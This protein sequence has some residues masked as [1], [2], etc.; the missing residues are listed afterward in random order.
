MKQYLDGLNTILDKGILTKNR[1]GVDTI[2]KFGLDIEYNL[3]R[4]V[5]PLLTTKRV[6]TTSIIHELIW[7]LSGDTNIKYLNDNK[8]TIWDEWAD[9]NGNLNK[10]YG[11]QWRNWDDTRFVERGS[12]EQQFCK[13][14]N[15][16]RVMFDDLHE[17]Y[18]RKIDQIKTIEDQ[19]KNNANSR[20]IIL[21]AWNTAEINEMALPPCHTLSQF[22]TR[23]FEG[24]KILDCKLYQRSADYFLGVPFNIAF[25][26][27]FTHMLAHV[28]G[29]TAG[30]LYHSIGDAHIYANHQDQVNTQLMRTIDPDQSLP[31]VLID[32]KFDSILDI[33]FENIIIDNYNPQPAIKAPVAV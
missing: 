11:H 27:I 18:Q 14:N 29:Y 8:V 5:I 28:H 13:S 17:V 26:A 6:H 22:S 7:M 16:R 9:K 3:S 32:G 4:H 31:Y 33:K 1:T 23:E 10:V 25:Y 21:T 20:R 30:T 12:D 2:S 19:L 24:E 15:F